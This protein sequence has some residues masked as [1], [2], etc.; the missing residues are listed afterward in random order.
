MSSS[1]LWHSSP[2]CSI[3]FINKSCIGL[4]Q[5]RTGCTGMC[6]SLDLHLMVATSFISFKLTFWVV[7]TCSNSICYLISSGAS[8]TSSYIS[9]LAL[10]TCHTP[11]FRSRNH[12]C[13]LWTGLGPW[14]WLW[15]RCTGHILGRSRELLVRHESLS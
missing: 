6:L 7:D 10:I 2:F 4:L 14:S 1:S 3:Y 15:N 5:R 13:S 9:P 12:R 11:A 8:H